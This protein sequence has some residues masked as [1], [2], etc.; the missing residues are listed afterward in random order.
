[1]AERYGL[2]IDLD[3][4]TGCQTCVL[5]CMMENGLDQVSGIRVET[6]GGT[7]SDAPGGS[8]PDLSM[9]YLPLVCMHCAEAPCIPSC[10]T[11]AI[12]KR[13]DGIVLIDDEK[14]NGCE[15]CLDACPYEVLVYDPQKDRVWKCNLCAPRVDRGLEPFCALCC[16]MEA[17]CFGDIGDPSSE[18]SRLSCQ[19][20]ACALKP[21]QGT[22]PAVNYCLVEGV[23]RT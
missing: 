14:C 2:V 3:R 8:Y 9:Y 23:R 6:V 5:A 12:Y 22:Y 11:E 18:I 4:C 13:R 20:R 7:Q 19:R 1:V 15:L 10:P 21:E 16:E 17:I